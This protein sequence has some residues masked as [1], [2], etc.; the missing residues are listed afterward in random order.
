MTKPT[1]FP[2]ARQSA[3][4]STLANSLQAAA[5]L[6]SFL[7]RSAASNAEDVGT[8]VSLLVRA[9]AAVHQLQLTENEQ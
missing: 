8:L 6:A 7:Q 9:T 2:D 4:L 3:A 5:M 1:P